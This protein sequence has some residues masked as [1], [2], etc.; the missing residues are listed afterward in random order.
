MWVLILETSMWALKRCHPEGM[1]SQRGVQGVLRLCVWQ[2]SLQVSV[3]W[4]QHTIN[5]KLSPWA[6][7]SARAHS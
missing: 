4:L 7:A 6:G 1:R 3:L 5:D 2:G